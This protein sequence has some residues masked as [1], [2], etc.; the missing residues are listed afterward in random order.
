MKNFEEQLKKFVDLEEKRNVNYLYLEDLDNCISIA[1]V[2][3]IIEFHNIKNYLS[4]F[5]ICF[6]IFINEE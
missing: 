4:N 1:E 5:S 2:Q 3:K 6:N